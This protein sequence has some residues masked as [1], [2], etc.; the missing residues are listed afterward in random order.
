M[1]SRESAV[2]FFVLGISNWMS[3]DALSQIFVPLSIAVLGSVP[4]KDVPAASAFFNLSRQIGGSIATAVLVTVLVR[5]IA[6]HQVALA[7]EITLHASAIQTF[8][9]TH[10]GQYSKSAL[11]TLG[12]LVAGQALV[13]SYADTSRWVAII[14]ILLSPLVFLLRRTGPRVTPVPAE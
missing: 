11:Q 7:G 6:G 2:G 9:Q 5:G 4:P 12:N 14:S 3:A 8:L 10:G 13:L 1:L